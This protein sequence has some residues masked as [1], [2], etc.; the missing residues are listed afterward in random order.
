MHCRKPKSKVALMFLNVYKT[1]RRKTRRRRKT[2]I[3]GKESTEDLSTHLY[4]LASQE[5]IANNGSE[6]G[7]ELNRTDEEPSP[8]SPCNGRSARAKEGEL[9]GRTGTGF[10]TLMDR[11]NP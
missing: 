2:K 5:Y 9:R 6:A 3:R 7:C 4:A 1:Y 11:R 8:S 10:A